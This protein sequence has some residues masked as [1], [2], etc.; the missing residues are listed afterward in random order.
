MIMFENQNR[1]GNLVTMMAKRAAYRLCGFVFIMAFTIILQA[2]GGSGSSNRVPANVVYP[3]LAGQTTSG[4]G[5]GVRTSNVPLAGGR[6]SN[7][8]ESIRPDLYGSNMP[9]DFGLKGVASE[10]GMVRVGIILPLTGDH[11]AV[12]N[13]LLQ[14]AQMALFDLADN[15]LLLIQADSKG[16]ADGA[17]LAARDLLEDNVQIILGP[18]FAAST[19][20]VAPA[21]AARNVPILTFSTDRSLAGNGVYVMGLLPELQVAR[22]ITYARSRGYREYGLLTPSTLYGDAVETAME[23]A[24]GWVNRPE[25][26][27]QM[28]Y[29]QYWPNIP[30]LEEDVS[31]PYYRAH[32]NDILE[33]IGVSSVVSDA[34]SSVDVDNHNGGYVSV[35]H[36]Q[37]EQMVSNGGAVIVPRLSDGSYDYSGI[38]RG[39]EGNVLNNMGADDSHDGLSEMA[40]IMAAREEIMIG[41]QESEITKRAEFNPDDVDFSETV[42]G[43]AD[44]YNRQRNLEREREWLGRLPEN[45]SAPYLAEIQNRDSLGPPPYEAVLIAAGGR[46]LH[47][48]APMLPFYDIDS[49]KTRFLG[50]GLWDQEGIWRESSLQGAWFAAPDPA[51]RASFEQNYRQIFGVAPPRIATIAYDAMGMAAA[52][53]RMH[54]DEAAPYREINLVDPRG[55][56]GRDGVFRLRYDGLVERGLAVLE[57]TPNGLK[58]IDPAPTSFEQED[59]FGRDAGYGVGY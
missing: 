27:L 44:Y 29:R 12:G 9:A 32:M 47:S 2:C 8:F 16:T 30:Y 33:D 36:G 42:R 26:E 49:N 23:S 20:A 48:L 5:G 35:R 58:V 18:L 24:M 31:P 10:D 59:D 15:R 1:N 4:N 13:A 56:S 41:Y 45:I 6:N 43:F 14:A 46:A 34:H 51:A 3:P 38:A 17:A 28:A 22:I 25:P 37:T 11:A 54:R 50:T 19:R 53:P 40:K 21:A 57:I 52:L 7:R 39:E 55:F